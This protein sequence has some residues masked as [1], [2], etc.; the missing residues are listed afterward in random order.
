MVNST[1]TFGLILSLGIP[2]VAS[3]APP[4]GDEAPSSALNRRE[5]PIIIDP[6]NDDPLA[7]LDWTAKTS[8]KKKA[9]KKKK[10]SKKRKTQKRRKPKGRKTVK[11]DDR[12]KWDRPNRAVD[13]ESIADDARAD[14]RARVMT[15]SDSNRVYVFDDDQVEGEVLMPSSEGVTART[16]A[17]HP[18]MIEI[19]KDFIDRLI[20]MS[21]DAR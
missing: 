21:N 5:D 4:K 8:P 10:N 18:S 17:D 16:P 13:L 12:V 6:S 14:L 9:K 7:G 20:I 3:A 15:G 2:P 11:N 1:L 19:R